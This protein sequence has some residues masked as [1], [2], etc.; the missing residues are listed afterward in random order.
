MGRMG[1]Y[2]SKTEA[3][4]EPRGSPDIDKLATRLAAIEA[5]LP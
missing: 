2:E 4:V 5:R 1:I 3:R